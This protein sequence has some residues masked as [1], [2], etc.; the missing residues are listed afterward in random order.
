[1]KIRNKRI[2]RIKN[3]M[4]STSTAYERNKKTIKDTTKA[5]IV[6]NGI[7]DIDDTPDTAVWSKELG[8]G[9]VTKKIPAVQGPITTEIYSTNKRQ[10]IAKT[11]RRRTGKDYEEGFEY[12]PNFVDPANSNAVSKAISSNLIL[13]DKS[14]LSSG[15]LKHT[16]SKV[17][18]RD[19][20]KIIKFHGTRVE[21]VIIRFTSRSWDN[22]E[23]VAISEFDAL[24]ISGKFETINIQAVADYITITFYKKE[25]SN[26]VL[27]REMIPAVKVE[28]I[29][30]KDTK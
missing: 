20:N 11:P 10:N 25:H 2:K 5:R 30:I 22:P 4:T 6:S 16:T 13:T 17:S 7:L 18:H 27:Q 21:N 9:I 26:L 14:D 3:R 19:T 15:N 12:S 1:M 24:K 8:D 23:T 29:W 28:H